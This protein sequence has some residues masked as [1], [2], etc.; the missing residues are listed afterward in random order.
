[1]QLQKVGDFFVCDEFSQ[2][3]KVLAADL[4]LPHAALRYCWNSSCLIIRCEY[5]TYFNVR[6]CAVRFILVRTHTF[7][8]SYLDVG[9]QTILNNMACKLCLSDVRFAGTRW[10]WDERNP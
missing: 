1:M 7:F 4:A 6:H 8:I 3:I 10:F 2:S 5:L 9:G